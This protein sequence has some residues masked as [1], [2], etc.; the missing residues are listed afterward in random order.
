MPIYICYW[1]CQLTYTSSGI[2]AAFTSYFPDMIESLVLIAPGG[3]LR[4]NRI[5]LGSK[6]L[7]S[8]LLPDFLVHYLVWRKLSE[9]STGKSHRSKS[10]KFSATDAASEE[11]PDANS[12][13]A[14]DSSSSL[15]E[16]RPHISS[17]T[18]V[19]WQLDSHPGFIPSFVSSVKY[20]PIHDG[21]DRWRLIGERCAAHRRAAGDQ[22][23]GLK[24]GKVLVLLGAQDRVISSDETGADAE[25]AFGKDNTKVVRLTGGHDLPVTNSEGCVNAMMEFWGSAS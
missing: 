2:A 12:A 20:A 22:S 9:G 1:D 5:S 14:Q 24:E 7:Y 16:D 17:A 13:H 3:V 11:I 4:T 10:R 19:A 23:K 25:D 21:H 6:L 15:F 18:A 8:G